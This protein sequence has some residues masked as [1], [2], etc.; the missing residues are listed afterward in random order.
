MKPIGLI[1][2]YG[3]EESDLKNCPFC[4]KEMQDTVVVCPSC[5]RHTVP[6]PDPHQMRVY[7]ADGREFGPHL[8]KEQQGIYNPERDKAPPAPMTLSICTTFCFPWQ[9]NP[10]KSKIFA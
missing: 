4:G 1:F 10:Q 3:K 7:S 9:D 6:E 2:P 5:F 8:S